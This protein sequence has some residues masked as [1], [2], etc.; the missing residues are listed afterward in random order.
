MFLRCLKDFLRWGRQRV[1]GYGHT[2]L[3]TEPGT[4]R[5]VKHTV[6]CKLSKMRLEELYIDA[7]Q[8]MGNSLRLDVPTWRPSSLWP[9]DEMRRFFIGGNPQLED[10]R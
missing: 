8:S 2:S 9:T 1:E 5:F 10:L 6:S 3:P 4:C 7:I